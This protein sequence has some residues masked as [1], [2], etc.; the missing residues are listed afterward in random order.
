MADSEKLALWET[1]RIS[2]RDRSRIEALRQLEERSRA[3]MHRRALRLGLDLL[4]GH[5]RRQGQ[6]Q[7]KQAPRRV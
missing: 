2:H 3:A 5:H 6:A 4:E 1:V 7:P